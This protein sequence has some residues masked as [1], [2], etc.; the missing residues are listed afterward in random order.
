MNTHCRWR[1]RKLEFREYIRHQIE[2]CNRKRLEFLHL[3]TFCKFC[4]TLRGYRDD[5]SGSKA[6]YASWSRR[7]SC[8]PRRV[9]EEKF[10]L[11]PT[12]AK[13]KKFRH[14][15][16]YRSFNLTDLALSKNPRLMAAWVPNRMYLPNGLSRLKSRLKLSSYWQS[17]T[18]STPCGEL[19]R[20][21]ET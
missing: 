7:C 4:K 19:W 1:K 2:A 21:S 18:R 3:A 12:T 13:K 9:S 17:K 8:S 15:Q 16:R 5:L 6:G 10:S 20:I 14:G 11:V